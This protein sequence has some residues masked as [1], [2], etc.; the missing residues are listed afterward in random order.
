M[1]ARAFSPS[2]PPLSPSPALRGQEARAGGRTDVVALMLEKQLARFVAVPFLPH[3]IQSV[4]ACALF[5]LL[6]SLLRFC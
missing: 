3:R 5:L 2:F 4:K 1:R 6:R